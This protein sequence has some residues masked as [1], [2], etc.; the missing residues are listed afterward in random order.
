MLQDEDSPSMDISLAVLYDLTAVLDL[1]LKAYQI[2]L[3]VIGT[4]THLEIAST[5]SAMADVYIR[6]GT[7]DLALEFHKK[8]WSLEQLF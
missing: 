3:K 4:E 7:F 2:R 6:M 5:Y 1:Y 8:H